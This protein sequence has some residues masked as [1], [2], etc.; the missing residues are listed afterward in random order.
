MS[1]FR[2][3]LAK[4]RLLIPESLLLE[5]EVPRNAKF[6]RP[7]VYESRGKLQ[8]QIPCG[9]DDNPRRR[10]NT[11]RWG[12]RDPNLTRAIFLFRT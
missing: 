2:V 1:S 4:V 5:S 12:Q 8:I 10:V 3:S 11:G 9:A 6:D 7:S